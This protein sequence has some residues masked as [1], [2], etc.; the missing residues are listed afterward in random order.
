[1]RVAKKQ[2]NKRNTSSTDSVDALFYRLKDDKR[3]KDLKTAF[4][5]SRGRPYV[6]LLK[7]PKTLNVKSTNYLTR[8]HC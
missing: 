8:R 4:T 7:D 6:I 5:D 1:M 2:N 3:E